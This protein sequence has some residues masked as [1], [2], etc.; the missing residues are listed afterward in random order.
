[1]NSGRK[2][3][4]LWSD[5]ANIDVEPVLHKNHLND[6]SFTLTVVKCHIVNKPDE[7]SK[8][9]TSLTN[10]KD[11]TA[12]WAIKLKSENAALTQGDL[13]NRIKLL[14]KQS[15]MKNN[16]RNQLSYSLRYNKHDVGKSSFKN[17]TTP[18]TTTTTTGYC[19]SNKK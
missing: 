1:M 3:N 6:D 2:Q 14:R 10:T 4:F 11:S 5:E 17:S 15:S 9:V 19:E 13:L 7:I 18:T 12:K 16:R 8:S